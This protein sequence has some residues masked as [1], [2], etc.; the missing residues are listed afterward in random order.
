MSENSSRG[1]LALPLELHLCIIQ[2][3]HAPDVLNLGQTCNA[4]RSSVNQRRVWEA[5]LRATCRLNQLFEPSYY[6]LEDLDLPELQRAA[7]EPWRRSASFAPGSIIEAA[8]RSEG[9]GTSRNV[10]QKDIKLGGGDHLDFEGVYIVPGGRYVLGRTE[11][12]ICL[13]DMGQTSKVPWNTIPDRLTPSS[14]MWVTDGRVIWD[15]SAPKAVDITS[16]RFATSENETDLRVYEVGPLPDVCSIREIAK[17][18][19]ISSVLTLDDFWLE[20]N[21]LV[22]RFDEGMVVWDFIQSRYTALQSRGGEMS[23]ITTN[24]NLIVAWAGPNIGVWTMPPLKPLETSSSELDKL[25]SEEFTD[26]IDFDTI[27]QDEHSLWPSET[28]LP[29]A[30]YSFPPDALEYAVLHPDYDR[31][32]IKVERVLL[33]VMAG[34]GFDVHNRGGV[35]TS[36]VRCVRANKTASRSNRDLQRGT[37]VSGVVVRIGGEATAAGVGCRCER[38]AS[39]V[40]REYRRRHRGGWV[41]NLVIGDRRLSEGKASGMRCAHNGSRSPKLIGANGRNGKRMAD[42]VSVPMPQRL[43]MADEVTTC[44]D[45]DAVGDGAGQ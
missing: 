5:A 37:G 29:S 36:E 17:L 41:S 44:D 38:E 31:K 34:G 18:Q 2:E 32:T 26:G 14:I 20:G 35:G 40:R 3:L 19:G 11:K 1:I 27:Q 13:W 28:Y 7:L 39:W 22:C 45:D 24:G 10:L 6:P 33:D 42:V 15:M 8:Y 25:F 9:S 21:T 12:Y 16:F 4:I 43:D 23:K 30:W